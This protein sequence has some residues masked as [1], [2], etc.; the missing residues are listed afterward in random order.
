LVTIQLPIYNEKYVVERLLEAVSKFDYPHEKLEIQILDDS[1][2]V[3]TQI[4]LKKIESL[5]PLGLDIKLLHRENR[6]GFKAGALEYGFHA[7]KGEFIAIFDADFIPSP[8][9]LRKTMSFFQDEK[10][11][12]VQTRWAHINQHYSMLTELQAFGLDAHFSVEQV[13]RNTH[14][15]FINLT[16]RVVSGENHALKMREAGALIRSPK[17]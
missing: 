15:S 13:A 5:R 10:V 16:A 12:V 14:G 2:D 6:T 1:T 3:T 17:I 7:A 4:I 8:D 9:F 11:G